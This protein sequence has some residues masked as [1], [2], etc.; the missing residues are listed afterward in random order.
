MARDILDRALP[1][2]SKPVSS[3]KASPLGLVLFLGLMVLFFSPAKA[4]IPQEEADAIRA[5]F[6]I[7]PG[8]VVVFQQPG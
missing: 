3:S 4:T 7:R 2:V 5:R 1:E 6:H 8:A